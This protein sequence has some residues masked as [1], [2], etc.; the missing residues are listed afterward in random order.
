MVT[1]KNRITFS[2]NAMRNE[3]TATNDE[4][5]TWRQITLISL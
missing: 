1:D 5:K 4:A 2:N 3:K